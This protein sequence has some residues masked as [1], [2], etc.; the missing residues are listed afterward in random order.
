M[1]SNLSPVDMRSI[2]SEETLITWNDGH[3]SLYSNQNLRFHCPCAQCVDERTGKRIIELEHLSST[4][5]IL[6]TEPVGRYG[7]RLYFSDG[8]H[9]GI[10]G[11][12]YLR[13]FCACEICKSQSR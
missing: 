7:L 1:P 2:G 13:S 11:F 3:R 4:I 9:T 5:Q 10:Y 12:E 8:H 6:K